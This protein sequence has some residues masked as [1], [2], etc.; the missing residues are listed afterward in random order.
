MDF[1]SEEFE[2][3]LNI[4]REESEEIVEKLNNNLLAL[5]KNPD[6]KD[7]IFQLFRDAHSLKVQHE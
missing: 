5:E 6:N 7:I 3:I 1:L 4:F 2:Q